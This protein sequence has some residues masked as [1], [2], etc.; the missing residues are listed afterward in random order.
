MVIVGQCWKCWSLLVK[1][2]NVGT[3]ANVW[4][5]GNADNIENIGNVD[6]VNNVGD[7]EQKIRQKLFH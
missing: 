7:Y 3:D 1:I 4:T 6:N 5:V 2:R